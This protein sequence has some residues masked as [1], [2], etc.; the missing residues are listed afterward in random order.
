MKRFLRTRLC[1]SAL[2]LLWAT[3]VQAQAFDQS[4]W[5]GLLQRHVRP[6]RGGVATQVDDAGMARERSRLNYDWRLNAER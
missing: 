1:L 6:I 3:L 5:D 4:T 2:C